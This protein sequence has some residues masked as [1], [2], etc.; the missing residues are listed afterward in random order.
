MVTRYH[1]GDAAER[2]KVAFQHTFREREFPADPDARVTLIPAD[3]ANPA[4]PSIGISV[5]RSSRAMI[6]WP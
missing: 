6:P 3:V 1:G 2:A 4:T 5:T